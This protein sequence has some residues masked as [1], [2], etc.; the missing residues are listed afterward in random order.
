MDEREAKR[1]ERLCRHRETNGARERLGH[2]A[3]HV[4]GKVG[5]QGNHVGHTG[6][7]RQAKRDGPEDHGQVQQAPGE[8]Y[9]TRNVLFRQ[10]GGGDAARRLPAFA[11]LEGKDPP[12][13]AQHEDK[14][15]GDGNQGNDAEQT[16]E[17]G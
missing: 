14:G 2:I 7:E 17:D 16:G 8:R 11:S 6:E 1:H 5:V 15:R 13:A 4:T 12:A 9:S 10:D 3:V